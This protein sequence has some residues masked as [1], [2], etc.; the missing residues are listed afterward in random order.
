MR[1]IF[2]TGGTG[3][4][5]SGVLA[6]MLA[7]DPALRAAVLL[8][9]PARWPALAAGLGAAAERV[10]PVVGDLLRPGLGLPR[11]A[12]GRLAREV[13]A[14]LHFAAD[15]SFSQTLAAARAVNV[16]GTER[17]LELAAEWP[18]VERVVF[19]STAFVAGRQTGPVSEADEPSEGWVNA[20]EQSKHEAEARVRA[21]GREWLV[22]R[23]STLVFD[24]EAGA[25]RQLNAAHRS[26]RL[27]YHGLAPM[28][29]GSEDAPVDVVPSCY[30]SRAIARLA[31]H[32]EAAGR[33]LHLCAGEGA[34]PLG[35]LLDLTYAAWSAREEWRRRGV[36]RPALTDL[37]TYRLFESA[38]EETGD[39]RFRRVVKSLSHFV[40]Q[41]ALPKRFD[42]RAADALLGEAAPPVR[43]YWPRMAAQLADTAWGPALEVAA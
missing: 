28:I 12:R 37:E 16:G 24:T 43:S 38:V 22:L 14:V 17:A 7:A 42:T 19:A 31:L 2:V 8:R 15:T 10:V 9:D 35:E 18:G 39:A 5:G 3:L 25:V 32:P 27:W 36:P 13:S 40:P 26:L 6:R 21:C 11:E 1:T 41:L 34:L 23:P 4:V 20:Y 30:V 33:T 29:P